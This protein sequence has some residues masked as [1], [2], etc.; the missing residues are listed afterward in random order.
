V[1][2]ALGATPAGIR[3]LFLARALNA[4]GLG[5]LL[6]LAG[7]ALAARS[8]T[9]LLFGVTPLD[10]AI[11]LLVSLL[12][13]GVT[14]AAALIPAQRASRTDPWLSLRAE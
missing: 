3:R 12:V 6:G 14:I 7:A 1:R 9:S 10:P 4:V 13:V 11:L 8:L 2:M 5:L